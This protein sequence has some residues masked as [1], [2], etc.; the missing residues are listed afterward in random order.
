MAIGDWSATALCEDADLIDFESDVLAWVQSTQGSAV[1]YRDKAKHIIGERLKHA[2]RQI[3]IDTEE[4][5]VLD[6]IASVDPL[7]NAAC[8]L[9][10]H[11]ICNDC[12]VGGDHWA[13][14]A[15]M[16]YQKYNDEMPY[17]LGLL[18]I[19]LDESGTIEDVE[20]YNVSG[21]EFQRGS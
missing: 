15:E 10:L 17:A 16:Y 19:D 12:S 8:Y 20:K 3:E 7:K 6:L 11:L 2:F 14:K 5:E 21:I 9:T 1:K 13:G 18:S 4:D